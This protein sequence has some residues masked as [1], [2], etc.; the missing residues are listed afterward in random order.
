MGRPGTGPTWRVA[1]HEQ[2]PGAAGRGRPEG[3]PA[4]ATA[5]PRDLPRLDREQPR[6][7]R[8]DVALTLT[9]LGS[10]YATLASRRRPAI[11]RS[12]LW[13]SAARKRVTGPAP[14]APDVANQLIN[15]GNEIFRW[16]SSKRPENVSS[17]QLESFRGLARKPR[18]PSAPN[19]AMVLSNLGNT[20]RALGELEAARD[21]LQESLKIRRDLERKRPAHIASI[22]RRFSSTWAWSFATSA[23][24][25]RRRGLLRSGLY[26][27]ARPE[28]RAPRG[29][30]RQ[31]GPRPE[32]TEQ[33][34]ARPRRA[35][36][37]PRRTRRGAGPVP[38]SG[39][40]PAGRAP[41]RPGL[42]SHQYG[43]HARSPRRRAARSRQLPRRARGV[44]GP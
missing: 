19:V 10:V 40:R 17:K 27:P 3:G 25:R 15:L 34:E 18:Q 2:E 35:G 39:A 29:A 11:S 4:T 30:P 20:L 1:S 32:S 26:D 31:P 41:D 42:G 5:R 14:L 12:K 9:N 33:S 28:P 36:G 43:R 44:P 8:S 24:R 38:L 23:S 6:G 22:S 16:E 7:Y 13:R 21:R 37:G